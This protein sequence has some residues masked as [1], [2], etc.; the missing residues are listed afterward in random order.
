[1]SARTKIILKLTGQAFADRSSG[2][3]SA[4]LINEL[5]VQIKELHP[6]HQFGIVVGGGN[7]FRGNY[8][9]KELGLSPSSGH[10]IGMLATCM[11]GLILKD[12]LE[13]AGL[14]ALVLSALAAP[15]LGDPISARTVSA[16]LSTGATLI[17]VG[18][19]G[20]PF[21][22]TDTTAVLRGL[23]IGAAQIWKA[24]KTDG[25]YEQD[26]FHFPQARLLKTVSFAHALHHNLG[27]MDATAFALAAQYQQ[28]IRVFNAFAPACLLHAARIHDFGSTI[29]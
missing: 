10:Q 3:P 25:V 14:P 16:A 26:P 24:T 4:V 8:Q 7:F 11:N 9:G 28:P 20:N 23:Q 12:L 22:T 6:T 5:I 18:G 15:E 2:A 17:F 27:I 29:Q 13:Q 19:T 21:F 1:M